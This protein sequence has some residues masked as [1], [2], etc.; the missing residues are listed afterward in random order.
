MGATQL[1]NSGVAARELDPDRL[2]DHIDRL[3]RAALGLCG[4]SHEAEDL[5]QETYSRVL[6]RPRFLRKGDDLG[7]L[8]RALRNTFVHQLRKSRNRPRAI[9]SEFE[10]V[11]PRSHTA[12]DCQAEA[13]ELLDAISMLP[14][15]ARL[16]IVAVDV[17]GLSYEE[18]ARALKIP[19]GTVRSR[20]FRAREAVVRALDGESQRHDTAYAR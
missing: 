3:Y 18:A 20:I 10:P 8:L 15:D 16:A 17:T 11:D 9:E 7:Y 1:S 5:V 14:T 12:P 13:H 2:G 6:A 4:N 19:I